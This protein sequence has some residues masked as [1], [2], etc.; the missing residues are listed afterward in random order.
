M[1]SVSLKD[2]QKVRVTAQPEDAKGAQST[3]FND[4]SWVSEDPTIA[5]I[6]NVAEDGLSADV[7]G[8][9][10]GTTIIT[11]TGQQGNF[12]P[13]YQSQFTAAISADLATQFDFAFATP[14]AQ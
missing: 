13:T 12:L 6:A 7:V 10:P 2:T 14:A 3:N 9:K 4:A 1:Q 8:Q 11:V 5:S